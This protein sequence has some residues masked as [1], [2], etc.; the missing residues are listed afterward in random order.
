MNP[1]TIFAHAHCTGVHMIHR[2]LLATAGSILAANVA[3]AAI[4]IERWQQPGGAQVYFV[5]SPGLPMVDV[6][7]DFDAGERL[8]PATK[9][10]LA[11]ATANMLSMGVAAHGTQPAM[12]ENQLGEAWADLG[13][14]FGANAGNDRFSVSLRSLTD[15][16]LLAPAVQLAA[17]QLGH[18]DFPAAI[19]QRDRAR[20]S[21]SLKEAMTRPGPV[22]GLAYEKAV[23]G[24]HPYGAETTA[25]TLA[26][27]GVADMQRW[28]DQQ[29]AP[30]RAKATVV[31]AVTRAQANDM[32]KTLLAQLPAS[33]QAQCPAPANVPPVPA[34]RQPAVIE[35]PFKAAQA[36]VLIGQ[37]GYARQDPRHFAFLVGNHILGEG[38]TSRLVN[39][40]REKRGLSYSVGSEFSPGLNGGGFT[41]GLQTKPEQAEQAVAVVQQVLS[42]YVAKGPTEAE[43]RAAKANLTGSFPL[44][45]DSNRKLLAN[46]ANIAWNQLPLDYLDTW[47]AQVQA[48]S[49]NDVKA[50]FAGLIHPD[51]L[52]VV[53]VG[54]KDKAQPPAADPRP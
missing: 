20:W 24:A 7:I 2:F 44:R 14:G 3:S 46:V 12:D 49:A 8:V 33:V 21:A 10:G 4:P 41:I 25:Q 26:D 27:I 51:R 32:V 1:E 28:R 53:V 45:I 15:P 54:A 36:Q 18:A 17:R 29:L 22:A 11:Q 40:V 42:D 19:W 38:F 37:P 43:M 47:N 5:P 9:A 39:E 13:A 34:L 52:A 50:A 30:C 23:Y 48:V 16:K 31:G 6:Q 35:L